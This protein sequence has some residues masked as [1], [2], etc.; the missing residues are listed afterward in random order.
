MISPGVRSMDRIVTKNITPIELFAWCVHL[1]IIMAVFVLLSIQMKNMVSY[2]GEKTADV[3]SLQNEEIRKAER[4]ASNLELVNQQILNQIKELSTN[5]E[6]Q[7]ETQTKLVN[8]ASQAAAD[9]KR[10]SEKAASAA[11]AAHAATLGTRRVL[12][13]KVPTTED[14]LQINKQKD[15]LKKKV[16]KVDKI[17]KELQKR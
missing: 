8:T 2:I 13:E 12:S 11:A 6:K 17:K 5:I 14:K 7:V 4:T 9:A 1:S 3:V 16:E 10:A 15:D